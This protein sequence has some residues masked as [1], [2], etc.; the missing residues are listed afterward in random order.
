MVSGGTVRGHAS[1]IEEQISQYSSQ[2]S[3]LSGSWEGTSYDKLVSE[4][5]SFASECSSISSGMEAFA[6]ACDLYEKYIADKKRLEVCKSELSKAKAGNKDGINNDTISKY[7][8][9]I[10]DLEN[11]IKN[12]KSQIESQLQSAASTKIEGAKSG[13]GSASYST[14]LASAGGGN[15][16]VSQNCG[17]VFPIE[18]GIYAP[19]T[20]SVGN[21]N[22]PT[23][24]ASTN[25]KGTDI[26]VGVGTKVHSLYNGT[27]KAAG[28]NGGYGNRVVIE[29]DDG[30][31][32]TYAHL[33]KSDYYKVGDKVKAGD[34]IAKSGNTGVSTG[35]HLHLEIHDSDDTVLNSENLF[36]DNDSWP[37]DKSK[38]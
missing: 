20:S 38:K 4:A 28:Y 13:G 27:V 25:H 1:E 18:S 30:R 29:Q 22:Q 26:G 37:G 24:G 12:L 2:I 36:S 10:T 7:N 3:G 17:Y 6:S 9:E 23:A 15:L 33:S 35:P 5:N 32:V 34:V 14:S 8:S 19:V 11:N 31:T 21:R 16:M